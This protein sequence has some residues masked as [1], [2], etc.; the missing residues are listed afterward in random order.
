ME[1]TT[2]FDAAGEIEKI[3]VDA[4]ADG[5]ADEWQTFKQDCLELFEKDRNHDKQVD[6]K[7]FYIEGE[8]QRLIKDEDYNG[9]FE[10]TQWF[11][12]KPWTVVI[13]KTPDQ[14][15]FPEF[16]YS[17]TSEGL[18]QTD[19]DTDKDGRVDRREDFD[20]SGRLIKSEEAV[21]GAAGFNFAWFYD[22]AGN[23]A[24]AEKDG[25]GDGQ[26]DIWYYYNQ[27]RLSSV[28]EDTNHDGRPDLW[29]EYDAS[30]TIIRQSK[31]LNADGRPDVT[32]EF[33]KPN[34]VPGPAAAETDG[35][36]DNE[37]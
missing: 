28:R 33:K 17:Y 15:K 25:D 12:R 5:F 21:D 7:I 18:R 10:I 20:A 1:R 23:P 14:G 35:D 22:E 24:R 31:D 30:E 26:P 34:A 4:N 29:E 3:A 32:K 37:E 36:Q 8:K 9:V 16:I 13:E 6:L 19:T 27:G 11:D 2:V